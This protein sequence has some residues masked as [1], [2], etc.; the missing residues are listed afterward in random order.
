MTKHLSEK[1]T[2][3]L[4]LIQK[5][6]QDHDQHAYTE[7]MQKYKEPLYF[8]ILK[9]VHNHEDAEDLTIEA[10]GK[11]FMNLEKYT[12][13]YAFSTWLFKI[14]SN[15][16]IDFLRKKRLSFIS[17][18]EKLEDQSNETIEG[19]ITSKQPDP[20]EAFI[21]SQRAKIIHEI[22]DSINPKYGKLIELRYFKE[23][24]Y[25]EIAKELDQPLG[26]IKVQLHRAK[27]MLYNIMKEHKSKY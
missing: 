6:V 2:I 18:N 1:A 26:T 8:M 14:A 10:F 23:Y 25:D 21:K 15:N 16:T 4:N 20:E 17:L 3:D 7:L 19:T 11:A 5:A 27:Q 9:M 13:T 12:P 24:S 22:I